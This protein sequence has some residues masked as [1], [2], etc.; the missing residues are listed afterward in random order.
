MRRKQQEHQALGYHGLII[1]IF[2]RDR[3]QAASKAFDVL[4]VLG[5]K[6]INFSKSLMRYKTP[7]YVAHQFD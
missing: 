6:E 2:S 1:L 4:A 7:L 3:K 5:G